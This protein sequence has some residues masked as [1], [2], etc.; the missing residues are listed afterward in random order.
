[1]LA[2]AAQAHRVSATIESTRLLENDAAIAG[3]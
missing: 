2:M 1:M 3:H